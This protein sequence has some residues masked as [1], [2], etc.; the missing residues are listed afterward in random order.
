MKI[1][2]RGAAGYAPEN[3]IVSIHAAIAHDVDGIEFDVRLTLDK[4]LVL[5]HDATL[6]R[7]AELDVHISDL[8]LEQIR[9][10]STL[11]G[12]P[13]PTLEEALKAVGETPV[14]IEVKDA[15]S[16]DRLIAVLDK[17]T[18]LDVSVASFNHDEMATLLKRRP[19]TIVY[20][21][22]RTNPFEVI[23]KA[24]TMHVAGIGLNYWI[25]NPLTYFLAKRNNLIIYVY[26]VN[27]PF[28]G[29]F[30]HRLYPQV[31]IC[32][33]YPDKIFIRAEFRRKKPSSK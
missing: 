17:F 26:T 14:I 29:H 2:H 16:V 22:E 21:L 20:L 23:Q 4:E 15:G 6:L 10:V 19:K 33:N 7:T 32:T 18:D 8:T 25:L 31:R 11:A 30:I 9:Q 27:R 5:C 24:H 28:I 1:G 12:E 3:T 13:I